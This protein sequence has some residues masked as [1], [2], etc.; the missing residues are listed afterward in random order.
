MWMNLS[1]LVF[2][3]PGDEDTVLYGGPEHLRDG[4]LFENTFLL[5]F[6]RQTDVDRAALCR[7]YLHP[8]TILRQIDLTRVCGIK[9][10]GRS[11]PVI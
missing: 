11:E 2:D 9:L 5:S 10:D 8:E 3:D 1:T 4:L 7:Q 6:D